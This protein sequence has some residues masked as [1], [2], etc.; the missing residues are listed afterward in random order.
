MPGISWLLNNSRFSEGVGAHLENQNVLFGSFKPKLC[1]DFVALLLLEIKTYTTEVV[2]RV[3]CMLIS[4]KISVNDMFALK[5]EVSFTSENT[6][7]K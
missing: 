2:D 5:L 1:K 4:I 6:D 3:L 7:Y